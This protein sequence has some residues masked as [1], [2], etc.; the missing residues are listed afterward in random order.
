MLKPISDPRYSEIRMYRKSEHGRNEQY[1]NKVIEELRTEI[2]NAIRQQEEPES[3][4]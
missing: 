4:V 2:A 1:A 3:H